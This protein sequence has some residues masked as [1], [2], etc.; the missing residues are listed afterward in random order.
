MKK[1]SFAAGGLSRRGLLKGVAVTTAASAF[2]L[3][4]PAVH[5][6]EAGTIKIGFVG[7]NSGPARCSA[8]RRH[9]VKAQLEKLF[10]AAWRSAARTT[11]SRFWCATARVRLTSPRR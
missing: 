11:P 9:F 4:F 6:A 8:R 3:R 5:G 7:A 1:E 10:A 2:T